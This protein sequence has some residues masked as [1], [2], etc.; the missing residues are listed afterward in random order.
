L[1]PLPTRATALFAESK[2]ILIVAQ[3]SAIRLATVA[4]ADRKVVFRDDLLTC[5]LNRLDTRVDPAEQVNSSAV[6]HLVVGH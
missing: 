5:D 1:Y 6:H 2:K 3:R 4:S